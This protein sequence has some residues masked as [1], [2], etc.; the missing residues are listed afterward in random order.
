M[1]AKGSPSSDAVAAIES[2]P[3]CG[4]A[5]RNDVDAAFEAPWRLSDT[6]AGSTPHE[7][8]GSGMPKSAALT[9]GFHPEPARWRLMVAGLTN[10]CSRPAMMKPSSM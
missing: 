8:S 1:M 5:M 9:T 7:H 4:V 3:V 6:A 10:V 2:T